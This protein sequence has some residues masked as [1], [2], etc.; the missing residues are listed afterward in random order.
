MSSANIASRVSVIVPTH[1]RAALLRHSLE[2][3]LAQTVRPLEIIVADDCSTDDT[4]SVVAQYAPH[5]RSVRNNEKSGKSVGVNL[6]LESVRG[7]FVWIFDDDDVS[8]PTAVARL[9]APLEADPT[10]GFTFGTFMEG[11]SAPDGSVVSRNIPSVLPSLNER[12]LIAPLLELNYLGGARMMFRTSTLRKIGGFNPAYLRSQDYEVAIRMVRQSR[13][14]FVG[15]GPLYLYRVHWT[16]RKANEEQAPG[17]ALDRRWLDFDQ[18]MVKEQFAEMPL[19]QLLTLPRATP[20]TQRELLLQRAGIYCCKLL[21]AEMLEDFGAIATLGDDRPLSDVERAQIERML[22][23]TPMYGLGD[24]IDERNV[25][26]QLQAIAQ[27]SPSVRRILAHA[28][29]VAPLRAALTI[30]RQRQPR[31]AWR[32]LRTKYALSAARASR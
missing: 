6:A 25:L 23:Y 11:V 14:A 32:I 19:E 8:L 1:S 17:A 29:A 9:S 26:G 21:F 30:V 3:L 10:L 7:D 13:G 31:R 5:V 28:S 18:R 24:V 16:A 12:G 2:A 20:A 15:G 22:Y 27:R 4:A